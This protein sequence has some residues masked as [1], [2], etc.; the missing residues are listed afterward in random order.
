MNGPIGIIAHVDASQRMKLQ[1]ESVW[2][3]GLGTM[4]FVLPLLVYVQRLIL[5]FAQA[6]SH[7]RRFIAWTCMS[8]FAWSSTLVITTESALLIHLSLKFFHP[9]ILSLYLAQT[10]HYWASSL[11]WYLARLLCH[12]PATPSSGNC[13]HIGSPFSGSSRACCSFSELAAHY[14]LHQQLLQ[15]SS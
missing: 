10:W 5:F 11:A 3:V 1:W 6:W 12:N 9:W 14:S 15:F 8:D 2:T 7:L 4:K 13:D